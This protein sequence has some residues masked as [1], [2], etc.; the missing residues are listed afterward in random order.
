ME[1][2]KI[3]YCAFPLWGKV[4]MGACSD[5]FLAAFWMDNP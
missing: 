3:P 1:A 2:Q 5:R 4:G